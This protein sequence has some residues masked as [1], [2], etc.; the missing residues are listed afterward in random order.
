MTTIT[1][2]TTQKVK[3]YNGNN[4]FIIKMKDTI[5]R[6]GHLTTAQSSAVERILN[7]PIES[8]QVEMTEDMKRVQSYKGENTFVK[9]IQSKLEKY[10]KLSDKQVSAAVNQIQKEEDKEK[11]INVNWA[12]PGETIILGRKI[13]QQLKEQYGLEFNPTLIDITRLLGVSQKAVRLAG[14]MTIKRGKICMSCGRDL[15]D[16]LSMVTGLGKTCAGHM[17]VPYIKDKSEAVR[18]R[19]EYLK[20][21]D[22]IGEF[23]FWIPK[24]QIK[25]WEGMTQMMVNSMY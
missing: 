6:Y 12:T 18:F 22:E 11:T 4:S 5:A 13:G 17:K 25:K 14:K 3:N 19:E 9:D 1:F 20:R 2:T 10:G 15:T 16:E 7:A 24:R 8:K 21:V 23:I